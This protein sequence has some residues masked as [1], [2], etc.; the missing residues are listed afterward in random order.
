MRSS[1]RNGRAWLGGS[2]WHSFRAARCSARAAALDDAVTI[3]RQHVAAAILEHAGKWQRDAEREVVGTRAQ[4][5]EAVTVLEV[6]GRR[7]AEAEATAAWIRGLP[8]MRSSAPRRA[9]CCVPPRG[10]ARTAA[11]SPFPRSSTPFARP[12][13]HPHHRR[14]HRSHPRRRNRGVEVAGP[15][16]RAGGRRGVRTGRQRPGRVALYGAEPPGEGGGRGEWHRLVRTSPAPL[17][18]RSR[19]VVRT[20]PGFRRARVVCART[21]L[22]GSVGEGVSPSRRCARGVRG[23]P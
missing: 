17:S 19:A 10:S 13:G 15:C 22:A 1:A 12:S 21:R 7:F 2:T 9:R 18:A 11:R 14:H 3:A 20:A 8:R 16:G 4:L 5:L 6:A 23:S